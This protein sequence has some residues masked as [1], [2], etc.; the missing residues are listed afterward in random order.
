[1]L[2]PIH[3]QRDIRQIHTYAQEGQQDGKGISRYEYSLDRPQTF[4]DLRIATAH[5]IVAMGGVTIPTMSLTY[6]VSGGQAVPAV[7]VGLGSGTLAAWYTFNRA[8]ANQQVTSE[9]L[10]IDWT[11][12]SGTQTIQSQQT[13]Q[14][15]QAKT[16]SL[17][18]HLFWAIARVV[19]EN[20]KISRDVLDSQIEL[21]EY[22][23]PPYC[24][25]KKVYPLLAQDLRERGF[26]RKR[27]QGWIVT[28]SGLDCF[29]EWAT[30]DGC[31]DAPVPPTPHEGKVLLM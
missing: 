31:P 7:L 30:F 28:K 18:N 16:Y 26:V 11:S 8:A 1:M 27:G 10:N 19:T 14:T 21:S 4:E 6:L 29:T 20:G 13:E 17:S 24:D 5:A 22:F 2:R 9:S 23:E 12:F 15:E 3:D 25:W